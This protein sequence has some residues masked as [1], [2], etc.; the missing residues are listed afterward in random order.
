MK[1]LFIYEPSTS[2]S[3]SLTLR[4]QYWGT[5]TYRRP[6]TRTIFE[7]AV[8]TWRRKKMTIIL[9][10]W[11]GFWH[12][13]QH[14][15]RAWRLLNNVPYRSSG[16]DEGLVEKSQNA[17]FGTRSSFVLVFFDLLFHLS[18]FSMF[19]VPQHYVF[20]THF[21]FCRF[22]AS[23]LSC[24]YTPHTPISSFMLLFFSGS[25]SPRIALYFRVFTILR[26]HIFVAFCFFFTSLLY[27][28]NRTFTNYDS[29]V[30]LWASGEF[31]YPFSGCHDDVCTVAAS[32]LH[33]L[34]LPPFIVAHT[35]IMVQVQRQRQARSYH[36][37]RFDQAGRCLPSNEFVAPPSSW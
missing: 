15:P 23:L 13:W 29:Q 7:G 33:T 34:P 16:F 35:N 28:F 24:M 25:Y 31:W 8:Y 5:P 18:M 19:L 9:L 22:P 4:A 37:R 32:C 3:T 17:H 2:T 27:K 12:P 1:T 30:A 20:A 14:G 6:S 11:H 10:L 21:H 26:V 36:L